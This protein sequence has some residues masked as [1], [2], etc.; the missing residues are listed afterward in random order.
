V[1]YDPVEIE[2]EKKMW[3]CKETSILSHH[4]AAAQKIYGLLHPFAFSLKISSVEKEKS[5][6]HL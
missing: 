2:E 5:T 3:G 4:A 1:A 6:K